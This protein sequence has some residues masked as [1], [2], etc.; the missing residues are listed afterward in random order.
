M[1]VL[2]GAVDASEERREAAREFGCPLFSSWRELA[3][4]ADA[5]VVAV[6]TTLHAEVGCGLMELG[7]DVLIEKPLAASMEEAARIVETGSRLGRVLQVGHLER[8]NPAVRALAAAITVP[9]F[10]EIHRMSLFTPRSLDVDVVLDLMIHDLDLVLALT[11]EQP[12]EVR[13]AGISVLSGKVDIANVRLAFPSGCVANLTA[14]RVSTEKVRKLRLFQPSEYVSVDYEKQTA[15]AVKVDEQRQIGFRPM[16]VQ[17]VEPLRA[18]LEHFVEC[19]RTR[20]RPQVDG[21]AGCRALGLAT[22]ILARIE[23]HSGQVR[24]TLELRN[25]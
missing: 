24:R 21:E 11:G 9:L 18:E 14:S 7:L 20:H 2:A 3:G 8:F 12:D 22:E 23:A 6:P 1:G 4:V 16:T 15:L 19:I 13:A 5:A 10:F 17:K 25:G